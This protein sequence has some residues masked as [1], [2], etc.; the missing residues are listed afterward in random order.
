MVNAK[1]RSPLLLFRFW[2]EECVV[3]DRLS[4][5][6]HLLPALHAEL[7]ELIT[8]GLRGSELIDRI[9]TEYHL[10]HA[11]AVGFSNTLSRDY[12]NLGLIDPLWN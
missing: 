11:E 6:T 2:G 12:K 10:S 1:A 7:L 5:D 3:Y 9:K 8:Q 4:G